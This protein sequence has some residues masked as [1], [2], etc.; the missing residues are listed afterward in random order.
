MAL[1]T[2]FVGAGVCFGGNLPFVTIG[3]GNTTGVY[4]SAG[5]AVAKVYNPKAAVH[6]F[7]L[8]AEASNGSVDN[9]N[10][11]LSGKLEFG[12]AQADMLYKAREGREPWQGTPQK[13]LRAV[14]ALYTEAVLF[15][16]RKDEDIRT[17]EDLRGK[18]LN[19]GAPGSSD[20][21]N[22]LTI[23]EIVGLDPE[24]DLTIKEEM[25][26]D[27]SELLENGEIDAYMYTVGHPSLSIREAAV[28][29]RRIRLVPVDP[30]LLESRARGRAFLTK[31]KVDTRYYPGL[32]SQGDM[33]TIGVKAILFT[34][35]DMPSE[36]VS[37][38]VRELTDNFDL[39]RRQHP[40]FGKLTL[41]DL[42]RDTIV[43]FHPGAEAVYRQHGLGP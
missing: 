36:T 24:S 28:G 29:G 41:E 6:G 32:E 33:Y 37:A 21:E 22:A 34:R 43:P 16:T 31:T 3:T 19:I 35:A 10:E 40:A 11:V 38:V 2:V 23:L 26:V 1:I 18:R 9:I 25:A 12:I 39:F 42:T 5:H 14:A 15:V 8:D 13:N 4:Y 17:P 7:R 27:A 20:N 30:A